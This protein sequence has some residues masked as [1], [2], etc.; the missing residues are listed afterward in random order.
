MDDIPL[1]F[2]KRQS[3]FLR[4]IFGN[5]FCPISLDPAWLTLNDGTVLRIAQA[6]YGD[7]GFERL[8]HLADALEKAGC[9]EADILTHCRQ[10]GKHVR[11]CWVLD[12]LLGRT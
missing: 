11:G 10:L 4:D 5:P 8:P 7:R 2:W 9:D 1:K 6:I 12:L 3:D